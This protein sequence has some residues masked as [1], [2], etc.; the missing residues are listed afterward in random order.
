[1]KCTLSLL[2]VGGLWS[3]QVLAAAPERV[4]ICH[5][6]EETATWTPITIAETALEAHLA[7]HDDALLAAG[8]GGTTSLT[9]TALDANCVPV[10]VEP[11]PEEPAPEETPDQQP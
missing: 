6:D 9:A 4:T 8:V 10:A 11:T 3:A 7:T 5:F 2:F 1:M